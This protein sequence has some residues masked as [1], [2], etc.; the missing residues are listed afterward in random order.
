VRVCFVVDLPAKSPGGSE[1]Q[2]RGGAELQCY[3]IGKRLATNGWDVVYITHRRP[4][5]SDDSVRILHAKTMFRGDSLFARYS[6]AITLF[7]LLRRVN[8]DI[9][10]V[11]YAGSLSGFIALFSL[12]TKKRFIYRSAS[13]LDADLTFGKGTGWNEFGFLARRLY[14]FAVE[15]ADAIVANSEDSAAAFRRAFP[16]R[17][18]SVIRN[19]LPISVVTNEGRSTALWIGRFEKVKNPGTFVELAKEI[20]D[21]RFIMCGY[22]SLYDQLAKQVSRVRNLSFLG[23][24][25]ESNKRKLLSDAFAFVNTSSS[26]GFPNTLLEAGIYKIPYIS[27]VDPDEVICRH[28]LGF[29]VISFKELV[30][31]TKLLAQSSDLQREL[32]MNIRSYVERE[33][34]IENVA[35]A[36]DQLLKSLLNQH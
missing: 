36:Y 15:K 34:R 6:R 1:L 10:V 30:E 12:L 23:M 14:S 3:L 8:P 19:G 24:V 5:I 7:L 22:G 33:H 25:D 27:F 11:T 9:V 4:T 28:K 16:G 18:I 29:H 35:K 32:G 17:N 21:V 20:P 31:K 26:E 2:V 13:I